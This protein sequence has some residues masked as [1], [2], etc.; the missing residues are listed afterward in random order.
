MFI[1]C[2]LV[3]AIFSFIDY[4]VVTFNVMEPCLYTALNFIGRRSLSLFHH[5]CPFMQPFNQ[6]IIDKFISSDL[7][8]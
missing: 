7:I 2:I 1:A 5:S 6:V 3:F 8:K 4:S